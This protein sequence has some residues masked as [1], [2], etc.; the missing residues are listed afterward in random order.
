MILNLIYR[1]YFN[2]DVQILQE[3]KSNQRG[4]KENIIIFKN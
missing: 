2:I 4:P 3:L 1:N